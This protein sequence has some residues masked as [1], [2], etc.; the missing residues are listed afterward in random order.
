MPVEHVYTFKSG[1]GRR[2][3]LLFARDD[4]GRSATGLRA[5]NPGA[6]AAYARAGEAEAH[7]MELVTLIPGEHRPGGF[8]E[9]DP[10]LAP[11][12]YRLALADQILAPGSDTA[13]VV[14]RF[15]GAT[16]DPVLIHLVGFDPQDSVCLG[17]A[18]LA[19]KNRHEFLRQA[20]PR[21][22]EKELELGRR[23]EEALKT[24][25]AE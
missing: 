9:L 12:V 14:V 19:N 6:S 11:G 25:R 2:E 15:T 21:L 4:R 23:Q 20:L 17:M 7:R 13:M 22:T 3:I 18:G 16:I 5:N 24:Q 8:V 1:S 10:V